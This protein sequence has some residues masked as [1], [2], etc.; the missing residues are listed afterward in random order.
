LDNRRPRQC[1]QKTLPGLKTPYEQCTAASLFTFESV[2]VKEV[3][4]GQTAWEGNVEVFEL[5]G[6]P[7]AKQAYAWSYQDRDETKF[8][9]GLR[10]SPVDNGE[11]ATTFAERTKFGATH[12]A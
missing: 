5:V 3:F 12:S 6:H 7:T 9:A 4:D 8:A 2:P 1:S 11:N 10:I